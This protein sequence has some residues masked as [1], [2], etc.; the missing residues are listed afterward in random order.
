MN[1]YAIN[2]GNY[3]KAVAWSKNADTR[4]SI[5]LAFNAALV[6]LLVTDNPYTHGFVTSFHMGREAFLGSIF[7]IV[8]FACFLVF[9]TLSSFFAFRVLMSDARK[10]SCEHNRAFSFMNI[11]E[12]SRE[13]YRETLLKMNETDTLHALQD[14]TYLAAQLARRKIALL[15][16]AWLFLGGAIF[17]AVTFIVFTVFFAQEVVRVTH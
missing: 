14:Q 15:S 11:T 6:A 10:T 5:V 17:S 9:F 1:I 4:A 13:E 7:G 3:R 8:L 12:M 2:E 16:W